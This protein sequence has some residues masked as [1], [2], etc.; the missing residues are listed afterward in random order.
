MVE[1]TNFLPEQYLN[2][3]P[4]MRIGKLVIIA[5]FFSLFLFSCEQLGTK[6]APQNSDSKESKYEKP[7]NDPKLMLL[8][9]EVYGKSTT[10]LNN[11]QFTV[12]SDITTISSSDVVAKFNYGNKTGELIPVIVENGTLNEG[13]TTIRLSI[14]AVNGKHK[15]W[16]TDITIKRMYPELKL[17]AIRFYNSSFYEFR[18]YMDITHGSL[19]VSNAM[20]EITSNNIHCFFKDDDSSSSTCIDVTIENGKLNVGKNIVK[21]SI[22]E[23][24]ASDYKEGHQAWSMELT[25]IRNALPDNSL[26]SV[27]PPQEGVVGSAAN[28][29][30]FPFVGSVYASGPELIEHFQGVFIEG[31]TVILSPFNIAET[32]TTYK[33][34]KEVYDWAVKN[35]YVFA[36]KG[37]EGSFGM[38]EDPVT[39]NKNYPVSKISWRDAIVWCNAYTEKYLKGTSECVYLLEDGSVVKDAAKTTGEFY[40]EHKEETV[41]VCDSAIMKLGKRG[42]RLPTEAEWEYAARYQGT[43][44]TNAEKLGD[45]YFTHIYSASGAKKQLGFFDGD[46]G[47]FSWEELKDEASRVAVYSKWWNGATWEALGVLGTSEV[48]KKEPNDLGLFDMAGNVDE[49]VFDLFA[50]IT[51]GNATNPQGGYNTTL[52]RVTRGG[53]YNSRVDHLASGTRDHNRSSMPSDGVGFR[54][55]CSFE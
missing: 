42:F 17:T 18:R 48:G 32:E 3:R 12:G 55:A 11:P 37:I 53:D 23:V 26:I 27:T 9:L 44:A 45:F 5:M 6:Y 7:N 38:E 49:W 24:E 20:T 34:W 51:A 10:D 2:R 4:F 16:N 33:L 21:L 50:S 36:N 15:A 52:Q 13:S 1:N 35:D 43:N 8:S 30:D 22:P 54:I 46:K 41:C 47:S 28:K 31:R 29:D 14:E 19:T 39:E 40:D 25:V